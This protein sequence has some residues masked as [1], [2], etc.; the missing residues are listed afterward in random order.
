MVRPERKM[1]DVTDPVSHAG[2]G[3]AQE[4]ALLLAAMPPS[5]GQVRIAAVVAVV[6]LIAFLAALP[7]STVQLPVYSPA[8]AVVDTILFLSD[9]ITSMLLFAQYS[10]LRSRGLLVLAAGYLFTGLIIIPHGLTYPRVFSETGLLGAG[11]QT[12]VWLYAFWHAGLPI[13]VIAYAVLPRNE[14]PGW[15]QE[16]SAKAP[17]LGSCAAV[18]ALVVALTVLATVGQSMLPSVMVDDTHWSQVRMVLLQSTTLLPLLVIA[19]ALTWRRRQQSILDLWLC[20][21]LWAWLL[22]YLLIALTSS[23]YDVFWYTGRI[24]G[25]VSGMLVLFALLSE[26]TKMYARL[27]LT[28]LAGRREREGR[29]MSM[30]AM[31]AAMDHEI[32][33]PIGAILANASAGQRWLARPVPELGEVREALDS[34]VASALRSSEVIGSFREMFGER[35]QPHT[36]IDANE[37]VREAVAL[38][39]HELEA[40]RVAVQLDLAAALPRVAAHRG[41]VQQVILNLLRNAADAMRGIDR[42]AV[43]RITSSVADADGVELVVSDTGRGIDPSDIDRVFDAF[44]T[45]KPNGMGM[46][47]AICR[48]IVEAHGGTLAVSP[49]VPYGTVFRFNLSGNATASTGE[50]VA[51]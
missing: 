20:A 29:M 45:T 21:V 39:Q 13:A 41:Q 44:Y 27:A 4:Q 12:A 47:L 36:R 3:M 28:V 14:P 1:M 8:I 33:Q 19:L 50:A 16:S 17:I 46:G 25:L 34:I 9:V 6:V 51:S 5:K 48:T 40:T 30:A 18:A 10:V 35:H 11:P 23:R 31:S 7:F 37:I 43:L 15:L 32:R 26:T 38:M 22:E 42:E 24:F 49:K 2:G